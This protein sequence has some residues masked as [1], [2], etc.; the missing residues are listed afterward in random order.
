MRP[1]KSRTH[2]P[3]S[4]TSSRAYRPRCGSVGQPVG[5]AVGHEGE[6]VDAQGVLVVDDVLDGL[7]AHDLAHGLGEAHGLLRAPGLD[8]VVQPL[9]GLLGL[10]HGLLGG[11]LGGLLGLLAGLLVRHGLGDLDLLGGDEVVVEAEGVQ[12]VLVLV[13]VG[14]QFL[15]GVAV[16]VELLLGVA[17]GDIAAGDE[18]AD[19]VESVAL[20]VVEG[21]EGAGVAQAVGC[22]GGLE[23]RHYLVYLSLLLLGEGVAGLHRAVVE[24]GYLHHVVDGDGLE[25]VLPGGVLGQALAGHAEEGGVKGLLV[26]V[27]RGVEE[28]ADVVLVVADKVGVRAQVV[29]LEVGVRVL[30]A[31][32]VSAVVPL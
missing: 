28:H 14:V 21:D 1:L 25:V 27:L 23:A 4:S 10:G 22:R 31:F 29:V 15:G 11:A 20:A 3:L 8:D 16:G 5:D 26:Q 2:Q 30:V 19:G 18:L 32:I 6:A 24:G 17:G 13:I 9:G 12:L 7:F